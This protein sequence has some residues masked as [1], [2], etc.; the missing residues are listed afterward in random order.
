MNSWARAKAAR[1]ATSG[2]ILMGVLRPSRTPLFIALWLIAAGTAATGPARAQGSVEG[3]GEFMMA[4]SQSAIGLFND[5]ALADE[6]KEERFRKLARK[7]FDIPRISKLVLGVHWR[8]ATP[9]QRDE[10]IAVFGEVNLRR[11]TPLFTRYSNQK[12]EVVKVRP[13]KSNPRL[14]FVSSTIS[15]PEGEPVA[16]EWRVS[17]KDNR[18]RILDVVAEGVSMVLTLRKEYG[19]AVKGSGIDGLIAQLQDKINSDSGALVSSTAE[20]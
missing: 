4:L 7:S 14:F 2:E 12:F 11:F 10:F 16:V 13:H 20:Q 8:K 6:Q 17:F 9:E 18:Y 1:K 19:S 5:E 15:R 3:A